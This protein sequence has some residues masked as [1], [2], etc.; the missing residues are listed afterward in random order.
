M[1]DD[2]SRSQRPQ[3]LR[4]A[5]F[6]L[7]GTL[8]AVR[9][10]Y[11]YVHRALGVHE[12][13]SEIFA[14]YRCGEL[15][16]SEWGHHEVRLWSGL[17][18]EELIRI[19]EDISFRPGAVE[20]VHRLKSAG[21]VVALV[22]AAFDLHVQRR[23]DQ[24]GADVSVF[25]ELGVAHG[26]LT[27]EFFDGVDSHNKG[28]LVASLQARFGVG[29]AET[30]TAGDT[31]YDIS[32]FPHAAVSVAVNPAELRVAEAARVVLPDGDWTRAWETIEALHPGWLPGP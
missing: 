5:V 26:R 17:P 29:P 11:D 13:A 16:Y 24:L 18:V 32:M 9:S 28:E 7:D 25:N 3:T 23:A 19:L 6:D 1:T 21:V 31:L 2:G 8:T 22:S 4:M 30:L 15:T 12:E 10:P 20:F 14:R 27:G